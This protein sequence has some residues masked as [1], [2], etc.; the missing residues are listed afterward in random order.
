MITRTSSAAKK[1]NQNAAGASAAP[2]TSPGQEQP[3]EAE[4]HA[5]AADAKAQLAARPRGLPL[6]FIEAR[7]AASVHWWSDL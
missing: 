4:T 3:I 1:S 7:I 6:S 5:E 2:A